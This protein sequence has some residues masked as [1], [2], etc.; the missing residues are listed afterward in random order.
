MTQFTFSEEDLKIA[1]RAN[2][3]SVGWGGEDFPGGDWLAP[4]T[5]ADHGSVSFK[6][7]VESLFYNKNL[8]PKDMEQFWK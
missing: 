7:A 3:W 1:L 4:C 8:T 6:K 2:G 5:N